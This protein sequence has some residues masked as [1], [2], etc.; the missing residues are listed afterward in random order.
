[1]GGMTTEAVPI[2]YRR[3]KHLVPLFQVFGQSRMA[4]K[5]ELLYLL[6]EESLSGGAVGIMTGSALPRLQRRVDHGSLLDLPGDIRMAPGAQ[7]ERLFFHQPG[8]RAGMGDV[9]GAAFFLPERGMELFRLQVFHHRLVTVRAGLFPRLGEERLVLGG[10][11]IMA[12]GAI[13]CSHRIM[14]GNIEKFI[15]VVAVVTKRSDLMLE[16]LGDLP[17]VGRMAIGA[18]PLAERRMNVFPVQPLLLLF[19]ALEAKVV[20]G[21]KEKRLLPRGMGIVTGGASPLHDRPVH[22]LG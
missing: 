21:G 2:L 1:M 16:E 17:G 7:L 20:D 13:A 12:L 14:D 19:M 6:G 15:L 18:D 22:R 8:E 4:G 9:A 3:M 11:R 10:M 5:A